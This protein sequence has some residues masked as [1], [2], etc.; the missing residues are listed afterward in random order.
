M[1][2]L[3]PCPGCQAIQ[4]V[5]NAKFIGRLRM[6]DESPLLD[7][8]NCATCNSTFVMEVTNGQEETKESA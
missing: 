1:K 2:T 3:K 8:Y 4:T 6:D 7:Y 5:T